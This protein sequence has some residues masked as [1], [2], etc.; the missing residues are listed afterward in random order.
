[1]ISNYRLM[2]WITILAIGFIT[3]AF[4]EGNDATDL[5]KKTQNPVAD[6]IS[7][8]LQSNFNFNTGPYN[9]TQYVGNLQP[10]LPFK[11]NDH[12]NFITRTIL[13]IIDQPSYDTNSSKFGI[14]DLN[15]TFF[16]SP[17]GESKFIWGAGPT[18]LLPTASQKELGT[19]KWGVGPAAVGLYM[20]GPW[21]VGVLVLAF[22]D[23]VTFSKITSFTG[24]NP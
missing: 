6:L 13:P 7:M 5:A 4:A 23:T 20:D 15:P 3:D 9:N 19:E 21:V 12:W 1:M 14:G 16:L 8:P 11:L 2:S 10:V 22:P 24:E 18:F 17:R